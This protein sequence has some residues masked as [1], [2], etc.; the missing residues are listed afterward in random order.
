M[1][2]DHGQRNC[3]LMCKYIMR[4]ISIIHIG[5]YV[6]KIEHIY[7]DKGTYHILQSFIAKPLNDEIK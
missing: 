3:R 2:G 5:S 4:E 1:Y 6:L 7:C